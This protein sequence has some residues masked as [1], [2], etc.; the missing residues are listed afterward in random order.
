MLRKKISQKRLEVWPMFTCFTELSNHLR[1]PMIGFGTALI[2]DGQ[3]TENAVR[4]ALEAGYRHLDTATAYFNEESVGRGI[5][6]SSV[7]RGEI[8]IAGK[9]WNSDQGYESTLAAFD[10]SLKQLGVDYF[11]MYLIHWPKDPARTKATWG[12]LEKLYKDGRTKA[13]GVCNFKIHHLEELMGY[14]ELPPMVNQVEIHPQCNQQ[15][16]IEFCAGRGIKVE[17]WGPLMQGKVFQ[18][19][20]FKTLARKYNTGIAQIV[21]RW[22][23]QRGVITIPKSASPE[24]IRSNILIDSFSLSEEDMSMINAMNEDARI[25][26][27][28]DSIDF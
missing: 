11:D 16:L 8:F 9:V 20:E 25:G 6:G 27:D 2:G 23:Y 19:E 3:T 28:P 5:E 1:I 17:A 10:A 15:E 14:A 21:L 4:C 13:I 24:R 22:H 18:L 12:A 26:P 7:P